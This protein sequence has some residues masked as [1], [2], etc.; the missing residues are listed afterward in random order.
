LSYV[1]NAGQAF[2]DTTRANSQELVADG[3]FVDDNKYKGG[4]F[5][6]GD[7]RE[8]H[9]R[10]KTTLSNISAGDGTSKTLLLSESLHTWYWTY[11]L[12]SAGTLNVQPESSTLADNKHL[13]GFVWKN[14]TSSGS[15]PSEIE[16]INGDNNY[17]RTPAPA[18]QAEFAAPGYESYGFPSSN[19][20]S[21]AQFAFCGGQVEALSDTMDPLV[22]AQ[23]M[24]QNRKKSSLKAADGTPER[25][26][27]QPSDDQY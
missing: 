10:I 27:P 17:D 7:D 14:P 21:T 4:A 20:P 2:S 25:Q 18:S 1:A 26:L 19:H 23:L 8:D 22:Y 12:A 15:Q 6:P 11:E 16:R 3:V 5:G 24:T 13:F 9:P